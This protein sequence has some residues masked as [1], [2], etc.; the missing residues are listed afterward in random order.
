MSD[1]F[2]FVHI[3]FVYF[4]KDGT[5]YLNLNIKAEGQEIGAERWKWK[6]FLWNVE[7]SAAAH[8]ARDRAECWDV[9]RDYT[10]TPLQLGSV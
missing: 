6:E 5:K 2:F 4:Q 1:G 8:W 3:Q 9:L 7:N 10:T